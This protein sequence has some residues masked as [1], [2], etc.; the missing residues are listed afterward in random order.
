MNEYKISMLSFNRIVILAVFLSSL[1]GFVTAGSSVGSGPGLSSLPTSF[2]WEGDSVLNGEDAGGLFDDSQSNLLDDA[3]AAGMAMY[4][5]SGIVLN[6]STTLN[7]SQQNITV[8]GQKSDDLLSGYASVGDIIK[9]QDWVALQKYTSGINATSEIPD[10]TL[11][12][13]NRNN[14]WNKLFTEPQVISCGG[15]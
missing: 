14:N 15:C 13:E 7:Q 2:E 4:S 6:N 1:I 10:S 5:T 12:L 3:D 8:S 9:A 11:S